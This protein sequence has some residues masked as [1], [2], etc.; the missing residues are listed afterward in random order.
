MP[1]F[2]HV[3][4]V[5]AQLDQRRKLPEVLEAEQLQEFL[6][7]RID[8]RAARNIAPAGDSQETPFDQTLQHA[9]AIYAAYGLDIRPRARLLVGNDRHRFDRRARQPLRSFLE[10]PL[11]EGVMLRGGSQ[12]PAAGNL[13]QTYPTPRVV[14]AHCLEGIEDLITRRALD[15][16][17][18]P[19]DLK[20][21]A[22]CEKQRL[23]DRFESLDR[24]QAALSIEGTVIVEAQILFVE[25]FDVLE[26][27]GPSPCSSKL[28]VSCTA[29]V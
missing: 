24:P 11:D 26:A 13:G 29:E 25:D 14:L 28:P 16:L 23:Y 27:H 15:G 8:Q 22:G 21:I 10:Q 5:I 12:L 19:L 9:S 20:G 17:T 4:D 3:L 6:G 1:G 18:H 2:G 7:S